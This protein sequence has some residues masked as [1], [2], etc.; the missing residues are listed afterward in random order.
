MKQL[1]MIII[2]LLSLN[3]TLSLQAK[4]PIVKSSSNITNVFPGAKV[5]DSKEMAKTRGSY[6][7]LPTVPYVPVTWM[8]FIYMASVVEP[9]LMLN[10]FYRARFGS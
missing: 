6:M 8:P 4:E 5:L 7:M 3:L 10:P 1:T 9:F 2:I